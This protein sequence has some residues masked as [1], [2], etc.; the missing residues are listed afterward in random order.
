V[1]G[2]TGRVYSKRSR[3]S[4]QQ[5]KPTLCTA[6]EAD[7]RRAP[8]GSTG[9][10]RKRRQSGGEAPREHAGAGLWSHMVAPSEEGG[11]ESVWHGF[12]DATVQLACHIGD[13]R[14]HAE[15]TGDNRIQAW[16]W[17]AGCVYGVCSLLSVCAV[18]GSP[19]ARCG[20]S[21]P[22]RGAQLCACVM[23]VWCQRTERGGLW[24]VQIDR[25]I[26]LPSSL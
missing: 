4:V 6:S 2:V 9:L 15:R 17:V 25:Y 22:L 24:V 23:C 26:P 18:R 13:L 3:R 5:A 14:T 19:G 11:R 10:R 16:G 21:W 8:G 1:P 12:W 7:A 20:M